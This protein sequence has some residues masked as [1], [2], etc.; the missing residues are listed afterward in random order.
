MRR[1]GGEYV[2]DGRAVPFAAVAERAARA[3]G[4]VLEVRAE[5]NLPDPDQ[6]CFIAQVAEVEVDPETGQ[7]RL[8]RLV[9]AHD[10]GTIINP[11]NHQGQIEGGVVQGIGQA[12]IEELLVED[13]PRDDAEPRRVQAAD[14]RR[15]AAAGHRARRGRQRPRARTTPRPSARRA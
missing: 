4:G 10:V 1:E 5:V 12:L 9:T 15:H 7:V 8:R 11:L 6:T 13:G 3:A 2:A 14:D